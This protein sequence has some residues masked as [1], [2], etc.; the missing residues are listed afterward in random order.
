MC[1]LEIYERLPGDICRMS[2]R[3]L[4]EVLEV[5]DLCPGYYLW[6]PWR[7]LISL[8]EIFDFFLE[9]IDGCPG[10]KFGCPGDICRFTRH[11]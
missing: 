3:Y 4:I 7:F 10:D 11:I 9:I 2:W 6:L 1:F 8:L 5:F